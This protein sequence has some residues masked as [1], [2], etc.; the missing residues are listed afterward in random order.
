MSLKYNNGSTRFRHIFLSFLILTILFYLLIS[1]QNPLYAE[2]S[3]D[4]ILYKHQNTTTQQGM[5]SSNNTSGKWRVVDKQDLPDNLC[6][7]Y[8]TYFV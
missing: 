5:F 7:F 3:T 2:I 4:N 1:F 6:G 8:S